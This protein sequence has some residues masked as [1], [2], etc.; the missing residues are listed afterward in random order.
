MRR[1]PLLQ[2]LVVALFWLGPPA[3]NLQDSQ[4]S[5][6]SHATTCTTT[7]TSMISDRGWRT[8]GIVSDICQAC[9]ITN[10]RAPS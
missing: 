6:R 9:S 2:R 5:Y 7:H 1:T 10:A 3:R 4:K 8:G